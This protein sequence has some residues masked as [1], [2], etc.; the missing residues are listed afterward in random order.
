MKIFKRTPKRTPK[1]TLLVNRIA[2][3]ILIV[4]VFI[5]A[6]FSG[7]RALYLSAVILIMLPLASYAASF[8]LLWGIKISRRQPK[9]VT[10][11]ETA[12]LSVALQNF[13]F[14]P[15]SDVDVLIN[16]DKNAVNVL[17]YQTIS[18]N[19]F[20]RR[21]LK[22]PFKIEFRGHYDFGLKAIQ[23][24]DFT[25][26]FRLRR[27]FDTTKPLLSLP[28]VADL[29]NFPL[30]M[31]LMTQASSHYDIRDEDYS[32]V[33]DIRQYLPTDSIKRVH[34]KLT[35]KRNEWLVKN[36]QSNALNLVSIILDSSRL[37]LAP[38]EFYA[39]E[40]SMVENA[41]GLA[42]FCLNKGLPVD[43]SETSGKKISTRNTSEFEIIF[44]VAR[45]LHF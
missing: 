45:E 37:P 28:H 1:Q 7:E 21:T 41:L 29:S 22:V 35:A 9:C 39:L 36:F 16:A 17:E 40:D 43:F 4:G 27:K 15:F 12:T 34:W 13:T 31:N 30:T 20:S 3:V 32:T 26:L 42:K 33:S 38:R 8:L 5:C 10:K 14:M 24:S 11:N 23:I 44:S 19:P 18:L 6:W 25:G 2:W